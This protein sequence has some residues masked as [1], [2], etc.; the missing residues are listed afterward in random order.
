MDDYSKFRYGSDI[1]L[2]MRP[3]IYDNLLDDRGRFAVNVDVFIDNPQLLDEIRKQEAEARTFVDRLLTVVAKHEDDAMYALLFDAG[4]ALDRIMR[5]SE[6][7]STRCGFLVDC[8]TDAES[9]E[10]YKACTI[11]TELAPTE[12]RWRFVVSTTWHGEWATRCR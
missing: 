2:E 8:P 5:W 11:S 3:K 6:Q 12:D 10:P 7:G 4:V 9:V 1:P